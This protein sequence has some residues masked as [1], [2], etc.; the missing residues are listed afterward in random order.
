MSGDLLFTG[1][2]KRPFGGAPIFP[3]CF[4]HFQKR[5]KMPL[6]F[7][8]NAVAVVVIQQC[9]P[10]VVLVVILTLE[11]DIVYGSVC[12]YHLVLASGCSNGLC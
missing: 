8:S 11:Q 9:L 12:F 7:C 3:C 6:F 2:E 4:S 5:D 1:V 10:F